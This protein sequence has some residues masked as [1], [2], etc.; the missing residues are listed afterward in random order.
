MLLVLV[1]S[2]TPL[3]DQR[4]R[5]PGWSP[6]SPPQTMSAES[7]QTTAWG[8]NGV[9]IVAVQ[10]A[11]G[12]C[13]TDSIW[14]SC[15]HTSQLPEPSKQRHNTAEGVEE[16]ENADE[17]AEED[18]EEEEEV[19]SDD[20]ANVADD[21]EEDEEEGEKV[22]EEKEKEEGNDGGEDENGALS[23]EK[24]CVSC[25]AA[26]SN[27]PTAPLFQPTAMSPLAA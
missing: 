22:E 1:E 10:V 13:H 27:T 8:T 3:R 23:G 15:P 4:C 17:D 16:D 19:L 21:E 14:L 11:E 7:S 20:D 24:V 5:S 12:R 9:S 6:P 18:E 2:K 26:V 25:W